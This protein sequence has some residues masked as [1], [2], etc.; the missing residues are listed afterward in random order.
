MEERLIINQGWNGDSDV[1]IEKEGRTLSLI[2]G[3]HIV[4]IYGHHNIIKLREF[5]NQLELDK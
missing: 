3:T 1:D 5:L 4:L 2:Q